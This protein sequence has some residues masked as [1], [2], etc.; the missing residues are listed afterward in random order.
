MDRLEKTGV[1][2]RTELFGETR[3]GYLLAERFFNIWFL[4]RS[5]SRRQRREVE[6]LTRFLE[7]FYEPTDRTRIARHLMSEERFSPDRYLWSRAVAASLTEP[8][9]AEE[10]KR[11]NDLLALHESATEARNRMRELIDFDSLPPATLAFDDLRKKLMGLVPDD[12]DITPEEFAKA[13]LGD[14]AMFMSGEREQLANRPGRLNR[15]ET[16]NVAKAVQKVR[17]VDERHYSAEALKWFSQRLA[18]GQLRNVRNI[19]DWDRAFLGASEESCVQMM[20][21]TLPDGFGNGLSKATLSRI[22]MALEPSD[23][24]P[25]WR[26]YNWGR[27]LH[28]KLA[29]YAE[30]A[31]AYRNAIALDPDFPL[32]WNGLGGLLA[33]YL[34]RYAE[35]EVAYR[36][37]IALDPNFAAPWNNLGNLLA[38][39]LARYTEAETVYREAI[40][41]DREYPSPWNGLGN[42]YCDHL[43]RPADAAEAFDNAVRLDPLNECALQNRLFLRR[44]FIG[45]G[46]AARRLM[47]EIRALAN[48]MFPDTAHLH[49]S[50][51]AAYDSNWGLACDALARALSL[52]AG[53]FRSENTDDWLRASAVLLHL[54]YGAEL[55][56]FLGQRGDTVARLRPWV[57]ALR[58]L[59]AGD[60]RA[61]QNIAP[62]IRIT[63]EV[64]YDGIESRLKKLPE[65]TRRRPV[66]KPKQTRVKRR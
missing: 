35:A 48:R 52:R 23:T 10:L 28:L 32:P 61:L 41:R 51:F 2:E 34:D 21:D 42:L 17:L 19:E 20:V 56:T 46:P 44:D 22:S 59:H 64:F 29:R 36:E 9:T 27:R 26:W 24:S 13:V 11:H 38:I 47:D 31:A 16:R 14:R 57:E 7:S 25:A 5:A 3:T 65:K 37:A 62:E 43:G 4:M 40:A 6:F 63:A 66:P 1:I 54:N 55:L 12:A 53:G 18:S 45:E 50:L 58:A 49:E 30:A 15:A 60:R 8:E 33:D 39:H